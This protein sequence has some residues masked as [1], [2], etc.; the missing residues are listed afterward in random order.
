MMMPIDSSAPATT[1]PPTE[2]KMPHDEFCAFEGYLD[3][4]IAGAPLDSA[5]AWAR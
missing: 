5:E 2:L 3:A 4:C 1:A